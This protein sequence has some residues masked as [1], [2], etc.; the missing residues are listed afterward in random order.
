MGDAVPLLQL[1]TQHGSA[2]RAARAVPDDPLAQMMW[3][4]WTMMKSWWLVDGASFLRHEAGATQ[5]IVM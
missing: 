5:F 2:A 1:H 4:W 3:M